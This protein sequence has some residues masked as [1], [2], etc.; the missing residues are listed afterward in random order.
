[1]RRTGR[2]TRIIDDAIQKLFTTD[3]IV[4]VC[5]ND[6]PEADS[7]D[8]KH[9]VLDHHDTPQAKHNLFK[10]IEKRFTIEHDAS[11]LKR[12]VFP[13]YTLELKDEFKQ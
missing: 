7:I 8:K 13:K 6:N 4:V 5:S 2:T 1:M 9:W 11:L 10:G 12:G 3:K